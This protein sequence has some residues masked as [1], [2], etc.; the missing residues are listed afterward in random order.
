MSKVHLTIDKANVQVDELV[1]F[2][3]IRPMYL[4]FFFKKLSRQ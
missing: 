1:L 3:L 2:G 4:E